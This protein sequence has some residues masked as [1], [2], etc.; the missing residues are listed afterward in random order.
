[1]LLKEILKDIKV[2][3][4]KD[5][6]N[7]DVQNVEIDSNKVSK[8][9]LFVCLKGTKTDGHKFLSD[10]KNK[11]AVAFVV[12]KIN[13][14]FNG[15]Q[16]LV[17][18]TRSA[19]SFIAKNYYIKDKMPKIIG[20]TGTNGKTTTTYMVQ[21]ILKEA[22]KFVGVIG[23]QGAVL[24]DYKKNY[25][26]TTPDPI[27]LFKTIKEMKDLGAEY[28]VMEVSAHAIAL[29]KID[30]L[31]FEVKAITN[32]TQDHLDF[33]KSLKNYRKTKLKFMKSGCCKKVVNLDDK[34][35]KKLASIKN[36]LTY[37]AQITANVYSF[38]EN[39]EHKDYVVNLMGELLEINSN[40]YGKYNV[41]N[42]LC[43]M[44]ICNTLKINEVYIAN[45]INGFN[46]VDGRFNVIVKNGVKFIVD[47][48]HTPDAFCNVIPVA[49]EMT[50]GKLFIV[51]GCG[52]NRDKSK[53]AKMGRIA[54]DLCD[55]VIITEDNPRFE[56][57]NDICDDIKSGI[58][59][60]NYSIIHTRQE[61]IKQANNLAKDGDTV[62][63]L[64]KG[65]EDYI[66][67]KGVKYPY[68]DKAVISKLNLE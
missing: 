33:F 10:A 15:L 9:D 43:A 12:E 60:D 1:M 4:S 32:I 61:A 21:S 53:R 29:K 48:A 16:I 2:L 27:E 35:T 13:K 24:G 68:Q 58:K 5:I 56:D 40:I 47:F 54:S 31:P 30:A 55:Y 20:I 34:Y 65:A 66:E 50:K 14:N 45:G 11:G 44:S 51:F 52:G 3:N 46:A 57:I 8:G 17:K 59:R 28:I 64:G 25:N 49:R 36:A 41:S 23:T 39:L 6:Q 7:I 22:K 18:D 63:I 67:K 37:S 26:M 42:A 19:L 62:L 38:N